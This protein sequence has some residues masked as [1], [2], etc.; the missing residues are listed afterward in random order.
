MSWVVTA[1]TATRPSGEIT[2]EESRASSQSRSAV[3]VAGAGAALGSAAAT[4][5][6]SST[7]ESARRREPRMNGHSG[8]NGGRTI[9]A[10]V[11]GA[12]RDYPSL[13]NTTLPAEYPAPNPESTPSAP[14]ARSSW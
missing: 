8:K 3:R 5:R 2:G 6:A 1:T 11:G 13:R 7:R 4:G 10:R 14:G 9:P 12:L